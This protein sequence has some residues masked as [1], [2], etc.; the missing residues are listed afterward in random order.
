[1]SLLFNTGEHRHHLLYQ[2]HHGITRHD[3]RIG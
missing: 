1:L 3:G 2:P